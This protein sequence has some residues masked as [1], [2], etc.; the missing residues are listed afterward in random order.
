MNP[1]ELGMILMAIAAGAMMPIQAGVN[2]TLALQTHSSTM[3]AMISFVVGSIALAGV[4]MAMRLPIPAMG[5]LKVAPWW[6]WTGGL[7]GAF[8][9]AASVI[10][11]PKLG[12]ATMMATFLAGQL[13]ASVILD[14]FGWAT[15]PQH[16]LSPGRVA[17]VLLLF[18]GVY[19]IRR[20]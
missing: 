20:Y 7:L 18:A 16:D 9:V 3:A 12:A 11:V 5:A 14:H 17:G 19:L 10:L 13:T 4:V 1:A 8:F 15:F 6:S 2:S